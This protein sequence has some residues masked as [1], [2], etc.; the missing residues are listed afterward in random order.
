MDAWSRQTDFQGE[1]GCW[2]GEG[3]RLTKD[4]VCIYAQFMDTENN[5]EKAQRE[6]GAGWRGKRGNLEYCQQQ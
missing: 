6:V 4:H 2:W 3:K 5:V 1:E